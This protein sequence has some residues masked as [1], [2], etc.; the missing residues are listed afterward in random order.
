MFRTIRVIFKVIVYMF[1]KQKLLKEINKIEKAG[2]EQEVKEKI[3]P[4][5]IDWAKY[6]VDAT[7][8]QVEV[9]GI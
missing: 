3:A 7:G 9:T 4:L 6:C 5:V 1:K 2:N 8:A